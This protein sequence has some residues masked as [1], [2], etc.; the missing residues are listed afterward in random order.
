MINKQ[1]LFIIAGT[2]WCVAGTMVTK[3]GIQ[4]WLKVNSIL[5]N[6]LAVI[7]YIIFYTFIFSKLVKKHEI[8]IMSNTNSK[9]KIWHFFDKQSYIIM[10]VMMSIG[11]ILRK[12]N[13]LSI[14]F[15]SFFY[16]GLGLALF[17]CGIRF[18]YLY[19]KNQ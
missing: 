3:T 9:M 8:R 10:F 2:V 18:I 6:I 13:L 11:I 4:A 19:Y 12:S 16:T 5:I 14:N 1:K 17:F 7:I 15:F